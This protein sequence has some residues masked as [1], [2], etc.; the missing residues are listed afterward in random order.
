MIRLS[1]CVVL[2]AMSGPAAGADSYAGLQARPVKALSAEQVQDLR[3][4]RGTGLAL[5]A[6]LN[7]YP[8]PSH[9]LAL[10]D[11]LKLDAA[12][13]ERVQALFDAMKVEA[14]GL[15][16]KLIARETDLDRLFA[17]RTIDEASLRSATASISVLQ[18]E[19][20]NAHLRHHLAT[21]DLLSVEQR[22]AYDRARGYD[23]FEAAPEHRH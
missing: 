17:T 10:A 5:A 14:I 9:V 16:E 3:A 15:G 2:L 21:A 19:L 7:G 8:G 22:A 11:E 13:R 12:Q 1:I 6:E 20:R 18:G 4:G 23:R